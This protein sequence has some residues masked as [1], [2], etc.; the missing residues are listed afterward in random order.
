MKELRRVRVIWEKEEELIVQYG[1][2]WIYYE[3]KEAVSYGGFVTLKC[4]SPYELR[5]LK[6][7]MIKNSALPI[8]DI[9]NF[10]NV[11]NMVDPDLVIDIACEE[12]D[13]KREDIMQKYVQGDLMRKKKA[14]MYVMI[15]ILDLTMEALGSYFDL[16]NTIAHRGIQSV[17]NRKSRE[18]Y[19]EIQVRVEKRIYKQ[20]T[21]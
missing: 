1:Y 17:Y 2:A 8:I 10:P 20:Q 13:V 3:G 5:K 7:H 9:N 14:I 19:D 11:V 18:W 12:L 15:N 21:K 4:P 6:Y 16:S